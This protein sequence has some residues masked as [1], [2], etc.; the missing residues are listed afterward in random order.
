MRNLMLV[1]Q[2]KTVIV[3]GL[4]YAILWSGSAVAQEIVICNGVS[5]MYQCETRNAATIMDRDAQ[6]SARFQR[7][8][9]EW[10]EQRGV[11][12]SITD[13]A[14]CPAYQE[15]LGMGM[16]AL[17]LIFAQLKSEGVQPDQWF[18]ALKFITRADPVRDDDVGDFNKMAQS[19]LAWANQEGYAW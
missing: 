6:I 17:P 19:W 11:R 15:I 8:V 4:A 18:W 1:T 3:V 12:S 13:G 7:L 16:D 9:S 5:S 2:V 10:K 14:M